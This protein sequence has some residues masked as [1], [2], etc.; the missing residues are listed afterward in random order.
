MVT[1]NP[2][3]FFFGTL[4][5]KKRLEILQLL[6]KNGSLNVSRITSRLRLNQSTVSHSLK[7]LERCNFVSVRQRGKQ[8]YYSL[9]Q[10]TILPLLKIIEEHVENNCRKICCK[11]PR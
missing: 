3:D 7:R 2:Y 1:S 6:Q 9:N 4:A 5:N 10:K 11:K 8:R